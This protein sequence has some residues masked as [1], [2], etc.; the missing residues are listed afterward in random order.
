[1]FT[2]YPAL[3]LRHGR[4]VRLIEGRPER[5]IVYADDPLAMARAWLDA[6]TSWLHVVDLDA[7][8][9]E[10]NRA[11]LAVLPR[12]LELAAHYAARVQWG[13]GVRT[14]EHLTRLLDMG[15]HRVMVGSMA[16]KHPGDLVQALDRW[17]AARLVVALDAREN[18]VRIA[19]WKEATTLSPIDLARFWA[20]RGVRWFLY[21]DVR[22]DG[23]LQGPDLATAQRIAEATRTWV[24]LAGGVARWEHIQ[25]A[26]EAGLAGVVVGRALYEGT[27]DLRETLRRLQTLS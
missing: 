1:M 21:T 10:D 27:L 5:E 24:L 13:G 20:D 4:V 19:G 22:R 23:T 8:F 12:L 18:R 17:G 11:N 9:G 14:L 15:V 3:D 7:A 2:L 16:V 26:R 6:G 25:A